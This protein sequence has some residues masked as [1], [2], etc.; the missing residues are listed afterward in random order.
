MVRRVVCVAAVVPLLLVLLIGIPAC[1]SKSDTA[2]KKATV[3]DPDANVQ[4]NV[5]GSKVKGG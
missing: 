2:A 5:G 4:P 3:F 1:G